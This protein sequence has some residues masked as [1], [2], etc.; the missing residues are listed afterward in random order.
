LK[1]GLLKREIGNLQKSILNALESGR[2]FGAYG[3]HHF[4]FSIEHAHIYQL[5]YSDTDLDMALNPELEADRKNLLNGLVQG[6]KSFMPEPGERDI[7]LK[8]H[9]IWASVNGLVLVIRCE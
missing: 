9:N 8:A 6:V 1:P 2:T 4:K 7:M 5:I 3:A